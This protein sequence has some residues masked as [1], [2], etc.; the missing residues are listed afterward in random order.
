MNYFKYPQHFRRNNMFAKVFLGAAIAATA[1]GA[2]PL[3]A[4]DADNPFS[5]LC[6]VGQCST[7]APASV[8]HIDPSQLRAGIQ[9]GMHDMESRLSHGD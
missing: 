9:Q 8:A 5:Q 2:A 3:A 4:A 6:M 1:I 7:P